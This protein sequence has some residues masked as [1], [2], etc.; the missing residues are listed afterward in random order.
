MSGFAFESKRS[1]FSLINALACARASALAYE[2]IAVVRRTAAEWGFE[3]VKAFTRGPHAGIV[4]C[5]SEIV[6]IAF[7]GTDDRVDWRTNLNVLFRRSP[8]AGRTG[9]S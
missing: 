2:G 4:L 1:D 7:R 8:L 6:L 3:R 5:S 9:A